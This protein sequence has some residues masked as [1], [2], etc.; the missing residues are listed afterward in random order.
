MC[1][2]TTSKYTHPTPANKSAR[3]LVAAVDIIIFTTV[4]DDDFEE[5]TA[6]AALPAVATLLTAADANIVF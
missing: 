4:A 3:P 2:T 5:D 6:A 1:R